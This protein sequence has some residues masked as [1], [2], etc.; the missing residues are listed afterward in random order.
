VRGRRFQELHEA[1]GE[2]GCAICR[3]AEESVDDAIAAILHE[4]VTDAH[5]REDFLAAGGFCH[6]H[7]WRFAGAHDILGTAILYRTLIAGA[8]PPRKR[9]AGCLLCASY[10]RAQR[11]AIE[12]FEAGLADAGLRERFA[13]S[14]GLCD[15]HLERV[16]GNGELRRLQEDCRAR[17]VRQLDDLIRRHDYRFSREPAGSEGDSWLRAVAAAASLDPRVL[18]RRRSRRLPPPHRTSGSEPVS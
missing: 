7:S 15:R 17:L 3:Q 2:R 8:R 18:P 4:Q 12:A 5:F 1:L 16:T 6:T 11:A 9:T 10:E 14:D 13:A